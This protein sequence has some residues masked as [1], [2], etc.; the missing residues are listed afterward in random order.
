MSH[1]VESEKD[2]MYTQTL[3]LHQR[4]GREVVFDRPLAQD[5]DNLK[6][7]VIKV[8]ETINN[9]KNK[10]SITIQEQNNVIIKL[11]DTW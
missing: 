5:K 1:N 6:K 4:W 11:H 8:Q 3:P 9:N 7:D 2:I 10:D